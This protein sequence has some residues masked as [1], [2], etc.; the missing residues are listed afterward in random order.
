MRIVH[1]GE[2]AYAG[3]TATLCEERGERGLDASGCPGQCV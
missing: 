2:H 3:E 1:V